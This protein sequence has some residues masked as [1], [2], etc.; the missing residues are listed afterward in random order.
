M[1]L[2]PLD[3]LVRIGQLKAEPAAQAEADG[4]LRSG[5]VRLRDA[6]N[7]SLGLESP[8]DRTSALHQ[9]EERH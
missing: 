2:A 3:N 9:G 1:S 7:S 4:L 6:G 5:K 8:M